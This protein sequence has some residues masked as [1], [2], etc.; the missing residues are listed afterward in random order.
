VLCAKGRVRPRLEGL[1]MFLG[2]VMVGFNFRLRPRSRNPTKSDVNAGP[3]PNSQLQIYHES[4]RDASGSN[5]RVP[6]VEN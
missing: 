2:S 4:T 1:S 6:E 3:K 5:S